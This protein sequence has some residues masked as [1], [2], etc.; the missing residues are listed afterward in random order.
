MRTIKGEDKTLPDL[1][2]DSWPL[3]NNL[4]ENIFDFELKEDPAH[5]INLQV[6]SNGP[7]AVRVMASLDGAVWAVIMLGELDGVFMQPSDQL[8]HITATAHLL[9]VGE[10]LLWRYYRVEA[11]RVPA[12]VPLEHHG[13]IVVC[14]MGLIR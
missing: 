3:D 1:S 13:T 8:F 11:Q 5:G 6:A 12:V 14:C 2:N 9:L 4:W 7:C 10:N